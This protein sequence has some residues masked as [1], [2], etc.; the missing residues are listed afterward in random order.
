MAGSA[1]TLET[2][3]QQVALALQPLE[4]QLTPDN[5]IPFL[6]QLGLQFPPALLTSA[7]RNALEAGASAA[8]ALPAT[9]TQLATDISN[10]NT[11]GILQDGEKLI[12]QIVAVINALRQI[13]TELNNLNNVSG[14]LPGMNAGEVASFAADLADNLV[15]YLLVSYLESIEP[16]IVGIVNLLGIVDYIPHDGSPGDPTH[17]PFT[18][19]RLQLSNLGPLFQS[20][21]T[22]LE[23]LYQ[24]GSPSFDG[25]SLIPRLNASLNLLGF[26]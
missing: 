8:A 22:F 25:T 24:W 11:S 16:G 6:S 12:Q 21:A 1:G 20:P 5:I 10:E 9:L 4:T 17:P 14:S 19:R 13:G 7:F 18:T 3:A 26:P 2:I 15:G 23:T